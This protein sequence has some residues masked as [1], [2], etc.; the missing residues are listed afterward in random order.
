MVYGSLFTHLV[1]I[2]YAGWVNE[3][4]FVHGKR[5][6]WAL[7]GSA[8]IMYMLGKSTAPYQ[9]RLQTSIFFKNSLSERLDNPIT[10]IPELP[11]GGHGAVVGIPRALGGRAAHEHGH[12]GHTSVGP[13]GPH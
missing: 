7:T 11:E 9:Q 5:L 3:M 4:H 13:H 6:F 10:A 8:G 12:G 2:P 1:R